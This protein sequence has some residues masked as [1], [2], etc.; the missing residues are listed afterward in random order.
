MAIPPNMVA[1]GLDLDDTEGLPDIEIP[2]DAPMEFPGGAEVI[3][4]GQGGAIIQALEGMGDLPSQEELIPFDANLS[5]F[6]DDGTLGELSSEL[7]GLYEEDLESRSEWEDAYVKGLDLLGLKTEDRTT[8]FEGASGITHPMV[9]ESVTQF[10]AQAYKE[11]LPSGGP[12]RT[13]VLGAKTPEREQQATRVKDFMNYQIME[14]MEEYDPDMDQLLYYLPLSGSTFKKVYFDPTKQRAVSKFIPAQD[15]VVPYSASDLMTAT[16]VTHVLRMDENEV[17]KMQVAGMYREVDL[18]ESSDMDED[19]VRQKVNE[20]EGLSKN[21]SDDVLTIL[22]MHADLDIEGFEDTDPETG[23]P[24]GIKLPYIVTLDDSSGEILSIRRNYTMEDVVRRKRQYFVHYKFTPGLGF[25]GFGLIHMIGGLGRAATSLLRQL[26]DAGTLANLPAGFKARGV[27]VRNDDEPLQPGEFRD[28][29]AP[30]GS[31]RDAIVPLPYKEPSGTLAQMLGGLVNDGRRFVALADQQMSDMSQETPVGTTV[32][33]LERGMKVMSAIHKRLHYAQKAEFRLLARIFAENLPPEYPYEVA[34][35]PAQAK[36]QDFDARIDVLPVSDPNIFSMSQRVTLAQTQLQLA[37]SNPQMHNLQAAYRR[38][39]QALEVQNIDE[40]LPPPP[41]PPPPADPAT[42]N[43]ML[44]S[45]QTPQSF[46]QQDHEAHIQAHLALLEL[47]ILQS[48][49]PVLSALF[50]HILQ[51]I[52]M[53][54][55]EMVDAEVGALEEAQNENEQQ[56]QQQMQQIQLLVQTGAVD[57]ASA[58]QMMMQAQQQSPESVQTQ[59]EPDQ[60]ESRVAQVEAQ[61]IKEITPLMSYKGQ[62]DGEKDPLVDIRM[63]ELSIKEMEANHKASIDQAKLELDGMRVEQRA[64]TDAA[65]MELQEQIAD[66]RS[67]V[68]RERIDVQRQAME[69]RNA[70]QDR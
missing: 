34:G 1:T 35:A 48:A 68:N 55:R 3:D 24:T 7:R 64:I 22:E 46:P 43:G 70:P 67:D 37:Q 56:V 32:A 14:V 54:A 15:L 58:Q 17:R 9:A 16:R 18:Q 31:I 30:G 26:I 47:S 61:L 8:P 60:I 42:E 63:K 59:F 66:D 39:Y 50:S 38:M 44:L 13:S 62:E 41:P 19:P 5:E 57:P 40:I 12:V 27:R 28:I 23:E 33:M 11:L 52:S 36:A 6:L 2:V 45:G 29:D 10:Q 21:Y 53:K 4:D 49:P 51:H 25:Y 20:L 65:R 69:Q